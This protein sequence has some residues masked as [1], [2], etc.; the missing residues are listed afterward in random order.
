MKSPTPTKALHAHDG[1]GHHAVALSALRVM[2]L[3]DSS[4]WFAQGLEIDYASSGGS[5][6]EAKANF[7]QGL[8]ATIH[9]HLRMYGSIE[10]FLKVAD[11]SAWDEFLKPVQ[12]TVKQSFSC[13]QLH[14][15]AALPDE[16]ASMKLPFD[17]IAFISRESVGVKRIAD[18]Q[19]A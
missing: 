16:L 12:E 8:R 3:P 1:D 9:E 13:V 7:E 5:Q 4:G 15:L 2:L 10:R 14:N 18:Y 6:D 11:K 17:S 19:P